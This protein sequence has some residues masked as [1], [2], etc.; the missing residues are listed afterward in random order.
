MA[1]QRA[2][3][4]SR[5]IVGD[6]VPDRGRRVGLL[7]GPVWVCSAVRVVLLALAS[8][9]TSLKSWAYRALVSDGGPAAG[10]WDGE[11]S[12]DGVIVAPAE[13]VVD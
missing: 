13:A 1:Q 6:P 5:G 12:A 3:S 2:A 10:N 7:E 9:L 11:V 4:L 8:A